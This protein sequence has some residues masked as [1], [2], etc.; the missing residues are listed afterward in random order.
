MDKPIIR[1]KLGRVLPGS[2]PLPGA[3]RPLKKRDKLDKLIERFYGKDAEMILMDMVEISRYDPVEDR[4]IN[5]AGKFYKFFKPKF[6]NEQVLRAR[7][8][9]FTHYFGSPV[10]ETHTEI[11]TPEDAT[12][13]IKFVDLKE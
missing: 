1:D 4:K 12:I 6:T 8:F 2:G 9:L 10:Q 7:Q 13:N 3:G 5:W 11:S